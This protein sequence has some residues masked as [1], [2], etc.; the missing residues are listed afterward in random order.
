MATRTAI[1]LLTNTET[2]EMINIRPNT[3]EIWRGKGKGPK[4]LKMGPKKQDPIRY[5][6]SDVEAW[7]AERTCSNTSQYTQIPLHDHA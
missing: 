7:I 5:V 1:T 3:L 6:E 2:A 4:F